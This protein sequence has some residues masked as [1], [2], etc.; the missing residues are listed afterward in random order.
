MKKL[1]VKKA[2]DIISEMSKYEIALNTEYIKDVAI[3][4]QALIVSLEDSKH[5]NKL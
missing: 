3:E 2:L 4:A 5:E 1:E